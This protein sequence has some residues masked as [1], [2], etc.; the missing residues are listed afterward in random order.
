MAQAL[1]EVLSAP[2]ADMI[3]FWGKVSKLADAEWEL[4]YNKKLNCFVKKASLFLISNAQFDFE[5]C[6]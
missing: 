5:L 4:R 1:D 3:P 2:N 6:V